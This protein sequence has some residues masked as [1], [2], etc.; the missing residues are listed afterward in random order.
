MGKE[1]IN[2]YIKYDFFNTIFIQYDAFK[3]K[4]NQTISINYRTP[5]IYLNGLFFNLPYSQIMSITK[6]NN[7]PCFNLKLKLNKDELTD[8]EYNNILSLF[9][10]LK[11]HNQDYFNTNKNKFRLKCKR[12]HKNTN[13]YNPNQC[14][15]IETNLDKD[16]INNINNILNNNLLENNYQLDNNNQLQNNYQL[17]IIIINYKIII[18]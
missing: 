8:K 13:Y 1:L 5:T 12:T 9:N 6:N 3:F 18:N 17:M 11:N 10:K 16:C 15:Q 7:Q 4:F 14:K 2:L